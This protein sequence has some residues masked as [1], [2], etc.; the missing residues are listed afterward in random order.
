M[1]K[2]ARGRKKQLTLLNLLPPGLLR[3]V[4]ILQ[5]VPVSAST[6]W[7]GVKDGR[8][9]KPMKLSKRVTVWKS[10]DIRKL[11]NGRNDF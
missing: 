3:L 2:K 1:R 7:S 9:P 6:W 8:F 10:E 4:V 5:F 11:I